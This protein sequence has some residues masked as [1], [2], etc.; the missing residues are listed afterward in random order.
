MLRHLSLCEYQAMPRSFVA[1][2]GSRWTVQILTLFALC[3]LASSSVAQDPPRVGI[4]TRVRLTFHGVQP[5]V[6]GRLIEFGPDSLTIA[7]E[8]ARDHRV[9][10]Q[11][12]VRQVEVSLRQESQVAKG[13]AQGAVA[14][15]LVSGA[16]VLVV[17]VVTPSC[18][19]AKDWQWCHKLTAG[20]LLAGIG[21]GA[22]AGAYFG[23]AHAAKHPRD[24]WAP[25]RW[26]EGVARPSSK[27]LPLFGLGTL[28]DHDVLLIGLSFS[29]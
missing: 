16:L 12:T 1:L 25:G 6:V 9:F 11:S 24:V 27:P 20:K 23:G 21:L 13:L 7:G 29:R 26:P 5:T 14:G 8:K 4:G 15:S 19:E 2:H 17:T 22:A 28:G 10:L 3:S 18:G